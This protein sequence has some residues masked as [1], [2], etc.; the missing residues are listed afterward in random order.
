[1]RLQNMVTTSSRASTPATR[2]A[3]GLCRG[4]PQGAPEAIQ[5]ADRWHLWHNLERT[6]YGLTVVPGSHALSPRLRPALRRERRTGTPAWQQRCRRAPG[7]PDGGL[8]RSVH[9][10]LPL[11][12]SPAPLTEF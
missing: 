3:L 7:A 5:V 2:T 12:L 1:M 11:T 9:Q 10:P 8:K 4:R 6:Q